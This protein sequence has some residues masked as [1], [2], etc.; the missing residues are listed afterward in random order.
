MDVLVVDVDD[1]CIEDIR[2]MM[3]ASCDLKMYAI[4]YG[5]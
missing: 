1:D 3:I 5:D 2:K 4:K